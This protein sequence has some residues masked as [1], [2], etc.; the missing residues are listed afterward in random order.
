MD[1]ARRIR[2]DRNF[3]FRDTQPKTDDQIFLALPNHAR[4]AA[5]LKML[6]DQVKQME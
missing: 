4:D 5:K 6:K 2:G 1:L 3:D